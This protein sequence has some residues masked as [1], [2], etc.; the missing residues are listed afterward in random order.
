MGRESVWIHSVILWD[1]RKIPKR[2][3]NRN[4]KNHVGWKRQNLNQFP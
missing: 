4:A 3:F 1:A 2:Y